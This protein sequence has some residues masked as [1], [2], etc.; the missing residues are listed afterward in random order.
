MQS[1]SR[2]AKAPG[3]RLRIFA[4][5]QTTSA[6]SRPN[7]LH[8]LSSSCRW[9]DH[10]R[11]RRSI[12]TIPFSWSWRFYS[13]LP[14]PRGHTLLIF[15]RI[16]ETFGLNA[17][18]AQSIQGHQ[19]A[20]RVECHDMCE[21]TAEREGLGRLAE[22]VDKRVIPCGAV[23]DVAQNTMQFSIGLFEPLQ[24][25]FWRTLRFGRTVHIHFGSGE[26][27]GPNFFSEDNVF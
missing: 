11:Q 27:G 4:S 20:M 18:L 25:G 5:P 1:D 23:S 21:D 8:A 6:R 22:R 13:Y 10:A 3:L 16:A 9:P 26:R 12:E 15:H 14:V 24:H 17:E 19:P 2:H 7:H